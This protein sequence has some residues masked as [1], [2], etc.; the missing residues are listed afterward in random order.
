MWTLLPFLWLLGCTE[1]PTPAPVPAPAAERPA[2]ASGFAPPTTARPD[3]V[4][5][6]EAPPPAPLTP[7][8]VAAV[9]AGDKPAPT[10]EGPAP[11]TPDVARVEP[12]PA[13]KELPVPKVTPA[14]APAPVAVAPA[15]APPPAPA[16][17]PAPAP[18]A[19]PAPA[20]APA[21]V[22]APAPQVAKVEAPAPAPVPAAPA[23]APA[24]PARAP[25]AVAPKPVPQAAPPP[26]APDGA[27]PLDGL[28]TCTPE[29]VEGA[30]IVGQLTAIQRGCM[31]LALPKAD[32][33]SRDRLSLAL[34]ANAMAQGDTESWADLVVRHLTEI[35]ATNPSL[36]YRLAMHR[37]E[38]GDALAAYRYSDQ[39]LANRA[40]FTLDVYADK[41]YAAHKLRTAA[42]QAM[43]KAVEAE[44]AAGRADAD[45]ARRA[46][47][48]TG[49]AARAWLGFANES[50]KD[51][52][53]ATTL[54]RMADTEC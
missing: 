20:P 5:V 39:A 46:K 10:A 52:R 16:P 11:T 36:S 33:A 45:D 3:R 44:R 43:W 26:T 7:A 6:V 19:T 13:P 51:G 23:P 24:A 29:E 2:P 37:Y 15:P 22:P 40:Q 47:E 53:A 38:Q 9:A 32:P 41:T 4:Q 8:D 31:E 1:E 27:D 21:P 34:I 35:D 25:V 28:G 50:G 42:A 49:L 12:A 54:C 17:A 48:R 14:P 30:A 18:T